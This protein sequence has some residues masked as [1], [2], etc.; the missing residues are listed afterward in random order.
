MINKNL[1]LTKNIQKIHTFYF[2]F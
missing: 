1:I 2:L